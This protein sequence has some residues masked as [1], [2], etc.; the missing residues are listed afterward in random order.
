MPLLK[1]LNLLVRFLLELSLLAAFGYWAFQ[2]GSGWGIKI[3]LA[4][5]LP[6]LIAIAWWLAWKLSG[7]PRLALELS[8]LG[9]GAAALFASERQ[10]LGWIYTTIVVTNKVLMVI[11]K[12]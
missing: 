7:T 9:S 10:D 4:I 5:G 11:W 12:Q 8:L 2:I 1:A 6:A 3:I